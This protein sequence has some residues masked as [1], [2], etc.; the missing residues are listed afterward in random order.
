MLKFINNFKAALTAPL[1]SAALQIN[2]D[3]I[4]AL[5]LVAEL[6]TPNVP[7]QVSLTL[8]DNSNVEVIYVLSA[9]AEGI[10][11][12]ARGQDGTDPI[13]WPAGA[14]IEARLTREIMAAIPVLANAMI[15]TDGTDVLIGDDGSVL[16][17]AAMPT[18]FGSGDPYGLTF[19]PVQAPA[20]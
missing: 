12:V 5:K 11:Q 18:Y 13:A 9:T 14:Q 8:F 4:S 10:A 20:Y 19:I 15:C 2:I 3:G 1:D 6:G 16:T 17:D 7:H